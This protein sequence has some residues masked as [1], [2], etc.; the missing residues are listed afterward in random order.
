MTIEALV[1]DN[2]VHRC[3]IMEGLPRVMMRKVTNRDK[4]DHS[5]YTLFLIRSPGKIPK[6]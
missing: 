1:A 2:S 6:L 4:F 3:D 5:I